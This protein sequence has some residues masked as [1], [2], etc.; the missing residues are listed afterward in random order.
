M[1]CKA[2]IWELGNKRICKKLIYA[3]GWEFLEKQLT[4]DEGG[5]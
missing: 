3:A 2:G 4:G 5:S 1:K